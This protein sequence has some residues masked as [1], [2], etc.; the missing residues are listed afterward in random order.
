MN[1]R[2]FLKR[3]YVLQ[4]IDNELRQENGQKKIGRGFSRAYRIN[5]FNPLSYL[6]I[7]ITLFFGITLF[8]LVGF[9]QQTDIKNPF[10]WD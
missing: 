2:N 4:V 10:K 8:G 1:M 9:W 3:I 7:V 5:P 6:V